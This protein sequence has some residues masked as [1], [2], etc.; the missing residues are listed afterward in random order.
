M[1]A[2]SPTPL[3]DVTPTLARQVIDL[4]S[5]ELSDVR[6]PDLDLS[7]LLYA[8]AELHAAQLEVERVEAE[9]EDKRAKLEERSQA[10]VSKAERALAY[11]RV[12]AQGDEDLAPRLADIGRKRSSNS[13][14]PN[15]QSASGTIAAPK[16]RGRK[17]KSDEPEELFAESASA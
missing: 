7:A 15:T 5:V 6:F 11:A 17:P 16:R 4:Y 1:K 8:Q 3:I 9:L 2:P 10:L 13:Q 12:F 14:S